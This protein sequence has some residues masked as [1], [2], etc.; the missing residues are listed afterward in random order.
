MV[1]KLIYLAR[2]ERITCVLTVIILGLSL[3]L[4]GSSPTAGSPMCLPKTF[5]SCCKNH[6]KNPQERQILGLQSE[7]DR[8]VSFISHKKV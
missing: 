4:L 5:K 3:K 8:Q 6:E 7:C 2:T 1:C